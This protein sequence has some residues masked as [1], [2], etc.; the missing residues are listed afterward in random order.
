MAIRCRQIQWRR[1][2]AVLW[3]LYIQSHPRLTSPFPPVVQRLSPIRTSAHGTNDVL[4]ACFFVPIAYTR[5]TDNDP[6]T[7]FTKDLLKEWFL[8]LTEL[9]PGLLTHKGR[10]FLAGVSHRNTTKGRGP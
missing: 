1:R 4:L 7:R 3:A 5:R 2:R 9:W 8:M 10:F 6:W